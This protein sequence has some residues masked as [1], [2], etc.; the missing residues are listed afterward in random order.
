MNLSKTSKIL[1]IIYALLTT[2]TILSLIA[3][4]RF[5]PM[6]T[7]LNALVAFAFALTHSLNRLGWKHA[8]ILFATT[9]L[10]SLAFESAGV[11]TGLVYG[12]YHYSDLLGIKVFGLVPLL[13]PI[14]WIMMS[15]P[16]FIITQYVLPPMKNLTTWRLSIAAVGA[17]V[18]TAWDLAMDP[19]M[20]AGGHWVWEEGGAYFGIPLQNFWGWWLTIFVTFT[21][22]LWLA[23]V[24]P[25]SYPSA[26]KHEDRL[27][28]LSYLFTGLGSILVDL[29]FGMGGAGLA[30]IFAMAP[31]I[32]MGWLNIKE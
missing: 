10:I 21:L 26:A 11:A 15:Y 13:I 32:I 28:I 17:M 25:E 9:F 23:R 30:G 4:V 6:L 5:T 3:G 2:Y 22:F 8:L 31:W 24:T 18:M 27:A 20:S 16:S 29:R 1:L 7:P 12:K 14:A 19:M